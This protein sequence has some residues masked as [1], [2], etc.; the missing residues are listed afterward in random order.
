MPT[1]ILNQGV[2]IAPAPTTSDELGTRSLSN[3]LL[4]GFV[5]YAAGPQTYTVVDSWGVQSAV[6]TGTGVCQLT[7]NVPIKPDGYAALATI[8]QEAGFIARYLTVEYVSTTVITVRLFRQNGSA[9]DGSFSIAIV[10]RP[11]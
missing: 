6:R 10:G 4:W 1:L 9:E 8:W 5:R 11:N 3:C 7:V 2:S